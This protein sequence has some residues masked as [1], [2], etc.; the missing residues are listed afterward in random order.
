MTILSNCPSLLVLSPQFILEFIGSVVFFDSSVNKALLIWFNLPRERVCEWE[1]VS[2]AV[3]HSSVERE[4]Y[5]RHH[6][7]VVVELMITH[8]CG[9]KAGLLRAR[10]TGLV[11]T[12]RVELW[13][14]FL[15]FMDRGDGRC[16]SGL[17]GFLCNGESALYSK[18]AHQLLSICSASPHAT[19]QPP[20]TGLR[21]RI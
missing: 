9:W 15:F 10:G 13:W 18:S 17:T 1:K 4:G 16:D 19:P 11:W 2:A 7:A 20:G 21:Y 6:S 8:W 12:A 14:A 5:L 3:T